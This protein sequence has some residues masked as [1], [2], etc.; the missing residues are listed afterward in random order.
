MKTLT[1]NLQP[2]LGPEMLPAWLQQL[3]RR[4]VRHMNYAITLL[5]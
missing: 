2:D 1:W 4:T 5:V 3:A